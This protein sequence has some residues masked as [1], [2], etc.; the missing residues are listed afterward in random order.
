MKRI[1]LVLS[2]FALAFTAHGNSLV[3]S[4]FTP[5]ATGTTYQGQAWGVAGSGSEFGLTE[6]AAQFTAMA[7]GD[8]AT[9]E[10]GLTYFVNQGPMDAFLYSDASG[11][12][13]A[14]L[15]L[16]GSATPTNAD[17]T[18]PQGIVSFGVGGIVPV[19]IGTN[20]WLVLKADTPLTHDTWNWTAPAVTGKVDQSRDDSTWSPVDDAGVFPMPPFA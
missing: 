3:F 16:L 15:G 18:T 11:S 8:L 1:V 12:P 7:S 14:N 10:L 4:S 9:V 13:A 17:S 20:Y 6:T 5:P 19:I 2:V